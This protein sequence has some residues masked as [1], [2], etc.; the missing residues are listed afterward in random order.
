MKYQSVN[1]K[2]ASFLL[3]VTGHCHN[4][5]L[6]LA[7][8]IHVSVSLNRY[9]FVTFESQEDALKIL[10]DVSKAGHDRIMK[11]NLNCIIYM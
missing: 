3:I 8:E 10:H 2:T 5:V 9:G 7:T 6:F 4:L 1:P 11:I